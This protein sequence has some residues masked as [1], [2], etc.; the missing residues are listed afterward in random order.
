MFNLLDKVNAITGR[1]VETS[2]IDNK[3]YSCSTT[4]QPKTPRKDLTDSRT[5]C[6]GDVIIDNDGNRRYII[7]V[8]PYNGKLLLTGRRSDLSNYKRAWTWTENKI[9]NAISKKGFRVVSN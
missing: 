5:L 2:S 7:F 1:S 6:R 4:Y 3:Q 8:D 9:M